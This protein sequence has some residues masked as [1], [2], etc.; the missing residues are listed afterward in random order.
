MIHSPE[1]R[2]KI[3]NWNKIQQGQKTAR[4]YWKTVEKEIESFSQLESDYENSY[5][6]HYQTHKVCRICKIYLPLERFNIQTS[7]T[8]KRKHECKSCHYDI[9][10]R[11][12]MGKLC[13]RAIKWQ[14]DNPE[15]VKEMRRKTNSLPHNRIK[16]AVVRR[17]KKLV[18]SKSEKY[19]ELIGCSPRELAS[20]LKSLF[21][22]GMTWE[23]YGEWHIDHKLP[24]RSFDLSVE[25]QRLQC[26][27]YTNL[28]PLW[29]TE[30]RSKQDKLP[31]GTLARNV[32]K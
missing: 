14:H 7:L 6:L 23:N 11:P 10:S 18:G 1:H 21:Q 5:L 15:K 17:L 28:Q 24:C 4:L 27:H 19:N 26:F 31:D 3:D 2:T 20:Y 22:P 13:K 9:Y 8:G 16:K 25:T 32:K 12:I 30:N 29:E